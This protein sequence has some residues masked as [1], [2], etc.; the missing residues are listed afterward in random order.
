MSLNLISE[1]SY[2]FRLCT[3]VEEF[4]KK[5]INTF[6][7]L[8]HLKNTEFVDHNGKIKFGLLYF[9]IAN[10]YQVTTGDLIKKY[11]VEKA[12]REEAKEQARANKQTRNVERVVLPVQQELPL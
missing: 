6:K 7:R 10:D 12:R 3:A 1:T 9:K 4:R 8:N 5:L 11:K 2:E